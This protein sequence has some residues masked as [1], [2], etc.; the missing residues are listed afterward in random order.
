MAEAEPRVLTAS[1]KTVLER[2]L[3]QSDAD[4]GD[5]VALVSERAGVS[6]RTVYRVLRCATREITLDLA[7]RLVVAAGGHLSECTVI[8]PDGTV[9]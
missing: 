6:S 8:L 7:D 1:V 9:E 3:K 4:Q 2:G 5:P